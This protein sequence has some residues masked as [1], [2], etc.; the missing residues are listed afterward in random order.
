MAVASEIR[1]VGDLTPANLGANAAIGSDVTL[2]KGT[3]WAVTFATTTCTV[4]AGAAS[5][6]G[7]IQLFDTTNSV[8]LYVLGVGDVAS[9]TRNVSNAGQA[10]AII[11][12]TAADTVVRARVGADAL[13]TVGGQFILE[14]LYT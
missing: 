9:Q 3:K 13:N 12:A 7:D 1:A 4:A 11:D 14:Q 2:P 6:G 5:A 8:I 10:L